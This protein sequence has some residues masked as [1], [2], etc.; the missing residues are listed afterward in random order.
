[1]TDVNA[2][3]FG[4]KVMAHIEQKAK[5]QESLASSSALSFVSTGEE[6]Y[7]YSTNAHLACAERFRQLAKDILRIYREEEADLQG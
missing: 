1:M 3:K 2:L 5:D 6:S 7:K 4:H